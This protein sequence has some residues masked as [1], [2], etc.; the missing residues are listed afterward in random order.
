MDRGLLNKGNIQQDYSYKKEHIKDCC[1]DIYVFPVNSFIFRYHRVLLI[2]YAITRLRIPQERLTV[3][4]RNLIFLFSDLIGRTIAAPNQ[5]AARLIR[6]SVRMP[7]A[8]LSMF[9]YYAFL[10]VPSTTLT[11]FT[12]SFKTKKTNSKSANWRLTRHG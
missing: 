9:L 7:K 10:S 2:I 3:N 11:P 5:P 6:N 4:K 8:T 12:F 1:L